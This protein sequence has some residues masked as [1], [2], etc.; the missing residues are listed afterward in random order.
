MSTDRR[1][2]GLTLI[3]L[4]VFIVIVSVALVGVLAV[5]NVAIKSSADPM[6][7]KQALAIAEAVL[8]EVMLQ[9][10][11]WCDPDDSAAA[12]AQGYTC[13]TVQNTAAGKAGESRG[14]ATSS[15]DNVLDFN[16]ETIST[17]ITGGTASYSATVT[18]AP[19]LLNDIAL[20][21][22]A[23]LLI[24]VAVSSGLETVRLQGYRTRYAPNNL[25]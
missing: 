6:I 13:T 9:P 16:G 14:S 25:P 3:E 18:V 8:E 19:V 4:I 7:R 11:T 10:F 21:S 1:Q 5:F 12:T 22:D 15:L 2:H 23:A 20:A 17:S 24:T